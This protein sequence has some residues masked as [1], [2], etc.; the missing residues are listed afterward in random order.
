MSSVN[1]NFFQIFSLLSFFFIFILGVVV[2]A[3]GKTLTNKL[4]FLLTVILNFWIVGSL[5]MS[6]SQNDRQIIFWDRFVYVGIVFWPVA[7]YHFGLAITYFNGKRKKIMLAGYLVSLIFLALSR[8]DYFVNGIFRYR[9]GMHT[10]AQILHH[11]YLIFFLIYFWMFFRNLIKHYRAK[12]AKLEKNRL[13]YFIIGFLLLNSIG[14][15]GYLP[16]YR[17]SIFPISLAAPLIFSILITYAIVYY[18]LMDIK[19]IMRRYVVYFLSLISIIIPVFAWLYFF[20]IFPTPYLNLVLILI[21]VLSLLVFSKLKRYY[22]KLSNKYFFSSL[23]D[24]RELIYNL[25]NCLRSSLNINRILQSVTHILTQSFRSKAIAVISYSL[26]RNS[27]S[28]LY[29]NGFNLAGKKKIPLEYEIAKSV[30]AKYKPLAI[31][32]IE[33]LCTDQFRRSLLFLKDLNV[34]V[35][36]PIKIKEVLAGLMLFGPK[37]SGDAYNLND[38]KVLAAIGAEISIS[39][40]NALLYQRIKKFND[41]LKE[42]INKAT[43]QLQEQN[44]ELQKL[45][46]AKDEFIGVVSHQLRTPLTGIR[47]FTELLLRNKEKNITTEQLDWLRQINASNHKMIKLVDDL[48]DVSHIETGRKFSINKKIFNLNNLIQEVLKENVFL[49]K[50]KKLQVINKIPKTLKI[51][52]DRDKIKQVWQNL[53][54]NAAKYTLPDKV[55]KISSQPDVVKGLIFSIQDEGIGIPKNQQVRLF[56]KFFRASNAS[57][58]DPDGTGLGLYIAREIIRAHGGDMWLKSEENKGS[59]FY[60][61][62]PP[63]AADKNIGG[64]P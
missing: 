3:R 27:W 5:M 38:L 32:N 59:I 21:L 12:S 55:I 11:F 13:W 58:Q 2:I 36:V 57:L 19:L 30:F 44:Q 53:M 14:A 40:E 52:A 64:R 60:F 35:A 26:R 51:A 43:K 7:Q 10:E 23:Y 20:H 45:D 22:F 1:A 56:E 54:S 63:L 61:S 29:D 31:Y 34:E 47:W 17:I 50:M 6:I 62:L 25:N 4:F 9:W 24:V 28:V 48:L 49:I 46:K 41:K 39:L 37:E 33:K 42:E 16:A 15:L 8:T 18:G